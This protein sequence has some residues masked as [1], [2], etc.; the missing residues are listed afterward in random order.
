MANQTRQ[1]ARLLANAGITVEVV[2]TNSPPPACLARLRGVRALAR[3]V[4]YLA[5]LWSAYRRCEVVHL[6]A[7]S[8]WA[9]HLHAAPALWIASMRRRPVVVNYRGGAAERF[10]A[11]SGRSVAMSLRS[12]AAVVVPS[13]F[14][15]GVFAGHGMASEVIPN[16]VDLRLFSPKPWSS[17]TPAA[18]HCVVTRSLERIYGNETAIRAFAIVKQRYS[19]A[20]LSIAGTGPELAYLQQVAVDRGVAESCTFPGR[21][22]V[23][24]IA[25]L[26]RSADVV[27]N[28]SRIDNM[29][30]SLLEALASGVPV[31]STNVGGVP[32]MVEHER[33][34]L[35]TPPDDPP[36][37]AACVVRLLDDRRLAQRIVS[38][39]LQHARQFDWTVVGAQWIDLYRRLAQASRSSGKNLAQG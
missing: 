7:N 16:I 33:T 13:G 19:E 25:A 26:V 8:G 28:P 11:R 10:L 9:W 23:E 37:M 15:Q 1:L 2:R 27:I 12:A 35:L 39:G 24:S 32:Y 14:L 17:D 22:G 6:M 31:V 34:A 21:L 4:P 5:S 38:A 36:A 18:P 20:R 29:P 30:N 3:L